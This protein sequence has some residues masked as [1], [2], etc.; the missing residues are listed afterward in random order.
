VSRLAEIFARHA[1]QAG[2]CVHS[3][4]VEARRVEAGQRVVLDSGMPFEAVTEQPGW[5]VRVPGARGGKFVQDADFTRRYAPLSKSEAD[6]ADRAPRAPFPDQ[7]RTRAVPAGAVVQVAGPGE[8]GGRALVETRTDRP[9]WVV[10]LPGE[11]PEWHSDLAFHRRWETDLPRLEDVSG[12][13]RA[14]PGLDAERRAF[15]RLPPGASL[16]AEAAG[17]AAPDPDDPD[18]PAPEFGAPEFGASEFGER[19]RVLVEDPLEPGGVAA[20]DTPDFEAS[21]SVEDDT[22]PIE[23]R[24]RPRRRK[25]K[26]RPGASYGM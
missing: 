20:L 7:A 6:E 10:T 18:A 25:R 4:V 14:V 1:D 13:Y 22:P 23:P 16:D 17:G 21:Y 11:M 3:P 26:A 8:A 12:L 15:L 24:G 2:V 9:G 19:G 5:L